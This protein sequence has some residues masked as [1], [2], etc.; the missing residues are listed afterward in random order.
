MNPLT[1]VTGHGIPCFFRLVTGLKCPGCGITTMLLA[2]LHGNVRAAFYANPF[3]FCTLPLL[4]AECVLLTFFQ[5]RVRDSFLIQKAIPVTYLAALL[6]F[7]VI[8]NLIR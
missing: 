4:L 6:L 1:H 8:R 7:G 2:L 3:L 5:K